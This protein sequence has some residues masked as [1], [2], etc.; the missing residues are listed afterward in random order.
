SALLHALAEQEV[1]DL[2]VEAGESLSGSFIDQNCVDE[3][4]L[5]VA[6][7]LM[8]HQA[9]ALA[10]LPFDRMGQAIDLDLKDVRQVGADLRFQYQ[11]KG[12]L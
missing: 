9:K 7:K 4:L 1:N 3:L 6:P 10:N 12:A 8:G 2:F 11:F 5:Y